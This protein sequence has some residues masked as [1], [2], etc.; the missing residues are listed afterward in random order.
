MNHY[1]VHEALERYATHPVLGPGS[2]TLVSLVNAVDRSSDGWAYWPK[3]KRAA[4]QLMAL[5]GTTRAYLEDR[6]R[7]DA[8]PLRLRQAYVPLRAFQT[9]SELAFAIYTPEEWTAMPGRERGVR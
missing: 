7:P 8:T 5:I 9:R 4:R 1:E 2:F 6:D 3:P